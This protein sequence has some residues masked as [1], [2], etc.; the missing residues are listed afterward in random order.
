ARRN[1]APRSRR[2]ADVSRGWPNRPHGRQIT[3]DGRVSPSVTKIAVLGGGVSGLAASLALA[4]DG[5]EVVLVERDEFVV[6]EPLDA[7]GWVRHGIPHFLQ[8]HAFPSRGRRELKTHFPDV[9]D[10]LIDAGADDIPLWPK[11]RGEH[12]PE[13]EELAILGVRRPLIEWALRR[14]VVAQPG[15]RIDSGVKVEG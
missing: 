14:A 10:A 4:R 6:G 11:L 3:R 2:H 8:A 9:F 5:H 7:P 12:R 1:A 13:D 15:I